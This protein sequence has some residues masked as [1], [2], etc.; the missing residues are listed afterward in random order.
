MRS[1]GGRRNE[2]RADM[3]RPRTASK[4]TATAPSAAIDGDGFRTLRAAVLGGGG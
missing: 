2:R 1:L 4:E 3:H